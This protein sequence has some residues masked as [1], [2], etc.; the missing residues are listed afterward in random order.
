MAAVLA[1]LAI[2]APIL[3]ASWHPRTRDVAKKIGPMWTSM[4]CYGYGMTMAPLWV[5]ALCGWH[6]RFVWSS[7]LLVFPFS[8]VL[9]LAMGWGIWAL[10]ESSK[11]PEPRW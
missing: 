1:Y 2:V 7:E 9:G 3:L 6:Y 11:P 4:L 8:L 5:A 10:N